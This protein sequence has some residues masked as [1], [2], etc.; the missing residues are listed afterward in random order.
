MVKNICFVTHEQAHNIFLTWDI[1]DFLDKRKE[2]E[3]DRWMDIKNIKYDVKNMRYWQLLILEEG[4]GD[5][6]MK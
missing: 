3:I 1:D 2:L 5:R 4:I 6:Y